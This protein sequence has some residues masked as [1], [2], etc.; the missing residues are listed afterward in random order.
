MKTALTKSLAFGS[1]ALLMLASC[2][3]N[4]PI[5]KT[6][7]GT[8]GA[9]TA[10]ATTLVLDK[11]KL[12]DTTKVVKF[13]FTKPV[14]GFTAAVTNTLQIDPAGD[15]W[16]NPTSVTLG[17]K[18]LSQGY[19]TA[20][21]N[22][23]LLKLNLP[24]GA[25]SQVMVRVQHNIGPGSPAIY[26]NVIN[27]T[28]TP[29]NLT[30]FLYLAGSFE[31]WAN[32]KGTGGAQDSLVSVTGNGVYVGV[33]N[34]PA[35]ARDFL[36]LPVKGDW[37][38]K[39]ATNDAVNNTSS[40]VAYDGPNNY[41]SPATPG[42]YLITFNTN[43]NTISFDLV[44]HYSLIGSAPPGNDWNTDSDMKYVSGDQAWEVVVPMAVGE[45]KVRQN[46]DWGNSW[47][48]PKAGSAGDGVAATLNNTS[49]TNIQVTAAGNYKVTFSIPFSVVGTSPSVTA[50]YT[51][52]KQ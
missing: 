3:K 28:V 9:L 26:S 43:T 10:N 39:Y 14:Y 51:S 27:L 23:L 38:H 8:S 41:F 47:G 11:T 31:G 6:N 30:S 20:D 24:A 4:D 12:T 29:F 52:V 36:V 21:F 34:F 37:S 13:T 2:K 44:N 45:F 42:M 5:I 40:T 1:I 17:T 22:N 15:N 19:S 35:G 18:V 7:G 48:I 16:A 49:N 46:H 32:Y 50:T 25:A 33:V